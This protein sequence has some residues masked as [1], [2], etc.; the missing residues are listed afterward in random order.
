MNRG[1]P[2]CLS[3]SRLDQNLEHAKGEDVMFKS[4]GEALWNALARRRISRA[5]LALLWL[6]MT[7]SSMA[8]VH[9][10]ELQVLAGGGMASP[11]KDLASQF[12]QASG[13]KVVI[14]YGTTPEL[15]KLSS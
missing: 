3:H 5:A 4:R 1:A 14:R 15:V 11:L 8:G 9:A 12:E 13:H 6:G 2:F 10:A 7:L